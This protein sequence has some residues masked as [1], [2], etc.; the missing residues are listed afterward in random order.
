MTF[1][2]NVDGF[3]ADVDLPRQ[4]II[5]GTML[6]DTGSKFAELFAA[7]DARWEEFRQYRGKAFHAFVP[8]DYV[9]AVTATAEQ[10]LGEPEGDAEVAAMGGGKTFQHKPN[11][12]RQPMFG[13]AK[14]RGQSP[15][16]AT[17][18]TAATPAMAGAA[19]PA[20][21]GLKGTKLDLT[22]IC[23]SCGSIKHDYRFCTLY[24]GI[25]PVG[26]R[27]AKCHNFHG[28]ECREKDRPAET[29]P[30]AGPNPDRR[31]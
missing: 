15:T 26:V 22:R 13:G 10:N 24:A 18:G 23:L 29:K 8:A 25:M 7:G 2:V 31:D 14:P 20:L 16:N 17:R 30:A 21:E 28:T 12:D 11:F 4:R 19:K 27:C 5:D 9:D 6:D 1:M 3:L